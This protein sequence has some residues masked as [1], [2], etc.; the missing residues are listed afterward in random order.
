L[1]EGRQ[2]P[3]DPRHFVVI[4][5][6][7]YLVGSSHAARKLKQAPKDILARAQESWKR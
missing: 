7:L 6:R 4:G 1:A 2:V 3:G 5:D